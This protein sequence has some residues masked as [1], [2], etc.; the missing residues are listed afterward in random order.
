M[1][2][3]MGPKGSSGHCMDGGGGGGEGQATTI[4]KTGKKG[5]TIIIKGAGSKKKELVKAIPVPVPIHMPMQ[6]PMPIHSYEAA[7]QQQQPEWQESSTH[8]RIASDGNSKL[9]DMPVF[10]RDAAQ[11]FAN[12]FMP[13]NSLVGRMMG[14]PVDQRQHQSSQ[15]PHQAQPSAPMPMFAVVNPV[16]QQQQ[17]QMYVEQVMQPQRQLQQQQ[18]QLQQQQRQSMAGADL[19][20]QMQQQTGEHVGAASGPVA[21]VIAAPPAHQLPSDARAQTPASPAAR[22][23]VHLPVFEPEDRS[24]SQPAEMQLAVPVSHEAVQANHLVPLP[25]FLHKIKRK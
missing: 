18:Q 25:D 4:V 6:M 17:Q 2:N 22:V 9:P 8:Q 16:V 11:S 20:K 3:N 12:L 23:E 10:V 13:M 21:V 24:D 19:Q 14:S 15:Q 5:N 1:I 7:K